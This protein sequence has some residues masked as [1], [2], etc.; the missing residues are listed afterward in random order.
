[1]RALTLVLVWIIR[2]A[3][4]DILCGGQDDSTGGGRHL[5]SCVSLSFSEDEEAVSIPSLP[6]PR[7]QAHS[8][9][10][11]FGSLFVCGGR[12]RLELLVTLTILTFFQ[13]SQGLCCCLD[14]TIWSQFEIRIVLEVKL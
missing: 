2:N 10:N 14:P 8:F 11:I 7:T 5:S 12:W 3:G 1:M 6:S 13:R 9:I 4:C